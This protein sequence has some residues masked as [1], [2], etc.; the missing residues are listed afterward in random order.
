MAVFSTSISISLNLALISKSVPLKSGRI[1]GSFLFV[2]QVNINRASFNSI[3]NQFITGHGPFVTY[4]HRF[5][6]CSHDR[7]V[8]GAKGDSN[9]Y[10]TIFP[11]TKPFHST[12][13]SA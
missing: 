9:H 7:C 13:P 4:L 8:C 12:K 6:L 1:D 3:D 5:G 11:V 2:P 10:A